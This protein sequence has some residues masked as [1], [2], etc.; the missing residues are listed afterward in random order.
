VVEI[1]WGGEIGKNRFPGKSRFHPPR[2]TSGGGPTIM[3]QRSVSGDLG[4]IFFV[5]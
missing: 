1:G 5:F 2:G 4:I 3:L